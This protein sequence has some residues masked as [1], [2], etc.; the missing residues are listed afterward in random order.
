MTDGLEG[1]LATIN[2]LHL[3]FIDTDGPREFFDRMLE[4]LL[5]TTRSEYGFIGEI[6]RDEDGTRYLKTHAL[7]NIAWDEETRRFYEEGAPEGLE[8]RNLDSLFGYTIRT[9]EFVI[10][11]SPDDDPRRAGTPGGHPALTAFLGVPLHH[12]DELVGMI[13]MANREGGYSQELVEALRPLWTT[14]ASL[15]KSHRNAREREEAD[16]ERRRVEGH[17]RQAQKMECV[18]QLAGGVAHDLNNLLIAIL[19]SSELM[20]AALSEG[21]VTPSA[22]LEDLGH[23]DAA[24]ERAA[25]LTRQL[26]AV[27]RQQITSPEVLD[28]NLSIRGMSTLLRRLIREDIELQQDLCEDI[29]PVFADESQVQQV[30]MNLILN[31][32]DAIRGRGRI[33]VSTRSA[34]DDDPILAGVPDVNPGQYTCI[35]VSDDGCGMDQLTAE[36]IFEPFFTTKPVG[37]GTGLGLA[38]VHGIVAQASGHVD[39]TSAPGEGTTFR[40]FLPV[41]EQASKTEK[42]VTPAVTSKRG[43]ETILLCEDEELVRQLTE[44][45]LVAQGY[46]VLVADRPRSAIRLL[47]QRGEPVELLITDVVMPGMSGRELASRMTSE[48]MAQQVLLVS[49][50]AADE[51]EEED[52]QDDSLHFLGKPYKPGQLLD[53]VRAILDSRPLK[54]EQAGA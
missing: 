7:T 36:R 14:A 54:V 43:T 12:Q 19:G 6:R 4:Q 25:A 50:Y 5:E 8:F 52:L 47:E 1:L 38:T 29:P 21:K 26:L 33:K 44:R 11:N 13:G 40:V 16:R 53:R 28:V 3:R 30:V 51:L 15:V 20:R 48:G 31:A 32:R 9:G 42:V 24:G 39:V 46:R 41:S 27:S 37:R 45:A 17:L 49:G 23:I 10:S 22:L 2:K 18:G 35:E 34:A